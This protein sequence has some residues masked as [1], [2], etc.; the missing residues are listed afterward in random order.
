MVLP[1]VQASDAA[2]AGDARIALVN[3]ER[4]VATARA[5]NA[6]WTSAED[7]LR[8]AE[9][10]MAGGDAAAALEH[11]RFAAGQAQLGLGQKQYPP[12]R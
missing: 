2:D 5:Q 9:R 7:A 1:A 8:R 10:A 12:T 4:A 11:A 6:L 3:A